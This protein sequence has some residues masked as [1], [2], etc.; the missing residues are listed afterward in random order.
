MDIIG[1]ITLFYYVADDGELDMLAKLVEQEVAEE[2]SSVIGNGSTSVADAEI[3]H[4]EPCSKVPMELSASDMTS[5]SIQD[6]G[7]CSL[8]SE[9][10]ANTEAPVTETDEQC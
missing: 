1:S 5:D 7:N 4:T 10:V 6:A 2:H 8:N 9:P 3:R